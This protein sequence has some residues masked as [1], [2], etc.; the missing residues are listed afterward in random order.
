MSSG[1]VFQLGVDT[2]AAGALY[3]LVALAVSLAY[4]GSG[5]VHLAIGPVGL[6]GG[7]LAASLF[8]G[9]MPLVPAAL[10][11]LAVGGALSGVAER[12][13]VA[14]VVGKPLLGMTILVAAAV[15]AQGVLSGLFPRPAYAF[16]TAS[17]VYTVAGGIVHQYDLVT[18]AAVVVVAG[19][20]VPVVKSRRVGG[21]LRLTATSPRQAERLGVNT[22]F[23]RTTSFAVGGVLATGAVLLG[24]ARFPLAAVGAVALTLRGIAAAAAGRMVSPTRIAGAALLIAAVEVVGGYELG[25]GRGELLCDAVAVLLVAAGWHR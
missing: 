7:L 11:G 4:S 24:S 12:A 9:G 22:A 5:V 17:G 21:S 18:L 13:L 23:V 1:I 2:L 25:G 3:A 15:L 14:P 6:A 19:V 8:S 20:S 16:P 10:A